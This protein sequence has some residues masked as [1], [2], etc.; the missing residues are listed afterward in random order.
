MARLHGLGPHRGLTGRAVPGAEV[1]VERPGT[2][3]DA[4][5]ETSDWPVSFFGGSEGGKRS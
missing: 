1:G 3:A 4:K 2:A 5:M